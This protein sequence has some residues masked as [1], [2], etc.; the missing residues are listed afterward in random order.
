[1]RTEEEVLAIPLGMEREKRA[2]EAA[3]ATL[4]FGK[5][6][7]P[8]KQRA[9]VH[10][11]THAFL[12]Y[13][14]R[15]RKLGADKLANSAE[16]TEYA[17][18]AIDIVMDLVAT[19]QQ[20]E[21]VLLESLEAVAREHEISAT[22]IASHEDEIRATA[23]V[24]QEDLR[25]AQRVLARLMKAERKHR[26]VFQELLARPKGEKNDQP[27]ERDL[28]WRLFECFCDATEASR[29]MGFSPST[30]KPFFA[31]C[32]FAAAGVSTYKGKDLEKFPDIKTFADK[33]QSIRRSKS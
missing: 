3:V 9:I 24:W 18:G 1:M 25:A 31:F 8:L 29:S 16:A 17:I 22:A 6:D 14:M 33:M 19:E 10:L 15:D 27:H 12:E 26:D 13:S 32:N 30:K 20:D 23:D 2:A 21:D 28:L 11:V 4:S 5:D 7:D